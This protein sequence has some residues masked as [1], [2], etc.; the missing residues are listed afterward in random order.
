MLVERLERKL[1][2]ME[3][4]FDLIKHKFGP[5]SLSPITNPSVD[6]HIK[7]VDGDNANDP[8]AEDD[9]TCL[10][11]KKVAFAK[12]HKTGSSTLQNVLFRFGVREDLNFAMRAKSW[13]FDYKSPFN[14]SVILDGPWKALTFDMFLFHSVWRHKEVKKF[15]PTATYITLLR[16]PVDCFESNYVY[17]GL[18]K[19]YKMDIN[20]FAES[21]AARG[22]LRRPVSIIGKNQE[23]WDLGMSANDMESRELVQRKINETEKEFDLVM[24]VER[25]DESMVLLQDLLCWELEDLTYL[26][27]NERKAEKKSKITRKTR[28]ILTKWLWA[29]YMLYNHFKAKFEQ[30]VRSYG[31]DKMVKQVNTLQLLNEKVKASCVIEKAG[32]DRLE[33]EFRMA[34]NIVYG[35]VIDDSK[36]WCNL[37]ARSE[38]NFF[39]QIRDVQD[40][41]VETLKLKG[42]I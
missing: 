32:N 40:L 6:A 35:Y 22:M 7:F 5:G 23:L 20:Q 28:E 33:G 21:K 34:L 15:L 37:F 27:Q 4:K 10:P 9:G 42:V 8:N 26:K 19:A 38:P 11:K 1:Q 25:F 36:P 30:R 41:K 24:I 31:V 29:D 18:E 17:M 2:S 39:K 16:D 13:M 12:T 3:K 14:A